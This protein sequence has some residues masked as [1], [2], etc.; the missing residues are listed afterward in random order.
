MVNFQGT[1]QW[2][3]WE[4]PQ[5]DEELKQGLYFSRALLHFLFF[6]VFLSR[7]FSATTWSVC[8]WFL[9]DFPIFTSWAIVTKASNFFTALSG[10]QTVIMISSCGDISGRA[11]A[12][13]RCEICH[14][15]LPSCIHCVINNI[16]CLATEP[17][18]WTYIPLT[19]FLFF[20]T[21]C[22]ALA[23]MFYNLLCHLPYTLPFSLVLK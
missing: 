8:N 19:I 12:L 6:F 16:W 20:L 13:L 2:F 10:P 17:I 22:T 5:S 1:E 21:L 9:S 15:F 3:H 18:P 7:K 4:V 14:A 11:A 23:K